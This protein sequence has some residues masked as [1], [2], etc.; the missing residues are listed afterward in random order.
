MEQLHPTHTKGDM[1]ILC[2]D[3]SNDDELFVFEHDS[4]AW[5]C[6]RQAITLRRRLEMR[7]LGVVLVKVRGKGTCLGMD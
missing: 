2:D 1:R 7:C 4:D 3:C 6:K 5:I